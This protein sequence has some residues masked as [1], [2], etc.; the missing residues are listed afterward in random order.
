MSSH[1]FKVNC[2]S[3]VRNAQTNKKTAGLFIQMLSYH[4]A[5]TKL[6][7]NVISEYG[8]NMKFLST[9][10]NLWKQQKIKMHSSRIHTTRSSS[11]QLGGVSA[12]VHAG[13]P[14]QVWAWTP[15]WCGPG[16][17]P[18]VNLETPSGQTPQLS[19]WVWTWKPP[20]ARLLNFP[21][22][23]GPGDLQG[24]LGYHLPCM[25]VYLPPVN[26]MNDRH[27]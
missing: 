12:S 14:P 6:D 3:K 19:P 5:E 11:C 25:L 7:F 13:I 10:W 17:P 26:R 2:C 22:G 9:L 8:I 4:Q 18:G 23:C 21:A 24:M 20:Q 27:V 15:P 16:D 1:Y